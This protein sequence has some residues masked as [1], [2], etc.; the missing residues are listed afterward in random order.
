MK[1]S[2]VLKSAALFLSLT[3]M[4]VICSC[5]TPNDRDKIQDDETD[6]EETIESEEEKAEVKPS[7]EEFKGEHVFEDRVCTDCGKTWEE[8]LYES[9]CQEIGKTPDGGYAE[10]TVGTT[11]DIDTDA[12]IEITADPTGFL[13]T[14]ESPIKD[15]L[16]MSY[17][18]RRYVDDFDPEYNFY[19]FDFS[20]E[21]HFGQVPDHDDIGQ[22]LMG[23]TGECDP[24]DYISKCGSGEIFEDEEGL[25]AYYTK[26]L[27]DRTYYSP[28]SKSNEM[29]LEEMF[30][31]S[32]MITWEQF[33]DTYLENY[34]TYL[35]S[36]E[37]VLNYY[38]MSLNG[39]GIEGWS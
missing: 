20:I 19:A 15:D 6:E 37:G 25:F 22:I 29:T 3:L 10:K 4:T 2:Y 11:N 9:I 13:I 23:T 34:G 36:I 33:Q 30:G 5:R 38:G 21:T 14:Y 24:D 1:R 35:D 32:E 18:I 28:D 17:T 7:S 26:E 31:D 27:G 12:V 8:C 16:Q 39:L